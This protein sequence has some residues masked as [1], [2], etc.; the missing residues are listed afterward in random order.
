MRHKHMLHF[1]PN[2]T[3]DNTIFDA[4][5]QLCL[6]CLYNSLLIK[7]FNPTHINNAHR[8]IVVF[9]HLCSIKCN[10]YHFTKCQ[11]R[12]LTTIAY[13]MRFSHFKRIRI[14]W[15]FY[16]PTVATRIAQCNYSRCCKCRMKC[17]HKLS[18]IAWCKNF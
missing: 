8:H 15:N 9:K 11:H 13:R 5:N 1:F 10:F 18:F 4:Y 17:A 2:T 14:A 12:N 7:R 3:C 6:C 16:T